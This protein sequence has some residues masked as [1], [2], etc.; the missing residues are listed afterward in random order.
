MNP[1]EY[2]YIHNEQEV[3][4]TLMPLSSQMFA[5]AAFQVLRQEEALP[6]ND[7]LNSA[8]EEGLHQIALMHALKHQSQD[9]QALI[10]YLTGQV[11]L[12]NEWLN[13]TN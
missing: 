1:I 2:S 13:H 8:L 3:V 12:S 10:E 11:P 5:Q 9:P 4:M 7:A 6:S